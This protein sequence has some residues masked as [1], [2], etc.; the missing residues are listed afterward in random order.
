TPIDIFADTGPDDDGSKRQE[1]HKKENE[2]VK[3]DPFFAFFFLFLEEKI[4][5]RKYQKIL[6]KTIS[7]VLV[8][9]G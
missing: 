1:K 9:C 8:P 2:G 5:D 4:D 6:I 3:K 7:P